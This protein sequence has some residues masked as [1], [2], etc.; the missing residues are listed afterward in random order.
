MRHLRRSSSA[1]RCWSSRLP[2]RRTASS[3]P[4]RTPPSRP[5][6]RS[7]AWPAT[8]ATSRA[9]RAS[10]PEAVDRAGA[11]DLVFQT[12]DPNGPNAGANVHQRHAGALLPRRQHH[13]RPEAGRPEADL[14]A[15]H[16]ARVPHRRRT[17]RAPAGTPAR[18]SSWPTTSRTTPPASRARCSPTTRPTLADISSVHADLR[19]RRRDRQG[20]RR[21]RRCPPAS[22]C[23]TRTAARP[24]RSPGRRT[25]E[26]VDPQ[27]ARPRWI[28]RAGSSA[29]S[30]TRAR[31]CSGEGVDVHAGGVRRA[32]RT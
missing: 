5:A 25:R 9:R 10:S 21:R 30:G 12:V 4:A 23:A 32:P 15:G 6:A 11:S 16:A 7:T 2:R 14:D 8:C 19:R 29:T 28:P 17:A 18:P 1:R 22:S 3:T 27:R 31:P 24:P 20:R 26:G 13:G